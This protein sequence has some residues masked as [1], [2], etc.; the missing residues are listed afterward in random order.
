MYKAEDVAEYILLRCA[1]NNILITNIRLNQILYRIQVSFLKSNKL[2]FKE[3]FEAWAFGPAIASVYYFYCGSGAS[4]I[5]YYTSFDKYRRSKE[6]LNGIFS[7]KDIKIFDTVI[8][9]MVKVNVWDAAVKLTGDDSAWK[10]VYKT[11]KRVIIPIE[12]IKREA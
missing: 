7:R 10:Q 2:A 5:F 3:P 8:I 12:L 11:G 1:E 9:E 4:E 6:R